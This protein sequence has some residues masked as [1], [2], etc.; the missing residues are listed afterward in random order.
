MK[1]L[2]I[3]RHAKSSWSDASL[4]DHDRPLNKRGKRDA[5]K[6]GNLLREN[7]LAPDLIVSSSA[8]R[9]LKTAEAVAAACEFDGQIIATRDLYHADPESYFSALRQLGGQNDV[10][11]VVGHNPGIEELLEGLTG[12]W[13]RMPTAALA[14]VKIDA[15][16]WSGM[17]VETSG[18]LANLWLPRELF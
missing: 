6:I 4:S 10:V 16:D 11:M 2:L 7:E 8:R 18:D 15:R 14:E 12:E 1:T 9:A 5:P 3:L 13:A 17:S